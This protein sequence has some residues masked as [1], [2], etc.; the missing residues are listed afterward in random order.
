MTG[1]I[2]F[3]AAQLK[4]NLAPIEKIAIMPAMGTQEAIARSGLKDRQISEAVGKSI[5]T[6]WRWRNGELTPE[7]QDCKRLAEILGCTPADL[8]PDLAEIFGAG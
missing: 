5:P 7:P 6:V 8:R 2:A 4:E 3:L 1:T